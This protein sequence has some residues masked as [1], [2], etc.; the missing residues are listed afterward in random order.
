MALGLL[1]GLGLIPKQSKNKSINIKSN[2]LTVNL[3]VLNPILKFI[4][5][6]GPEVLAGSKAFFHLYFLLLFTV[7]FQLG[8][9]VPVQVGGKAL[10]FRLLAQLRL[11]TEKVIVLSCN[12]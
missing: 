3:S 9:V 12:K 11:V 4:N 1:L 6:H 5:I 10:P 8:A 7:S 2:N